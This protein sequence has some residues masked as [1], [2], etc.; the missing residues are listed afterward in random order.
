MLNTNNNNISMISEVYN[1]S[2]TVSINWLQHTH[3]TNNF[4]LS[5]QYVS[6][7]Q[8]HKQEKKWVLF[9]NPEEHSIEQLAQTHGIDVSKIL[10]V[11]YKNT[12]S[13][14]AKIALKQITSVLSKGNCAAVILSN[15]LFEADEIAQLERSAKRGK[16]HCFLVKQCQ[17][18]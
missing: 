14:R 6:I 8:Q 3:V 4:E 17:L 18:H 16:T 12:S 13:T 15:S 2:S 1:N 10:M 7:C 11:N 9:I 5:N